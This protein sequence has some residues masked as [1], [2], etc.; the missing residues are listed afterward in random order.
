[1]KYYNQLEVVP[2]YQSSM[3]QFYLL[4]GLVLLNE[5]R[6]YSWLQLLGLLG[7]SFVVLLGII[8]LVKKTDHIEVMVEEEEFESDLCDEN[9][10]DEPLIPKRRMS[11]TSNFS[12]GTYEKKLD[13]VFEDKPI[14]DFTKM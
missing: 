6:F 7:S 4:V 10:N 13:A 14:S 9:K 12:E 11:L 8:V 2:V 1:M 5:S 3:L